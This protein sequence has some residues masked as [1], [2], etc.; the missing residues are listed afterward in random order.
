MR[1][2]LPLRHDIQRITDNIIT[3]LSEKNDDSIYL[4][5]HPINIHHATWPRLQAGDDVPASTPTLMDQIKELEPFI[6]YRWIWEGTHYD[7]LRKK[8]PLLLHIS[9]S[10][11]LI[12]HFITHWAK[13]NGG[14][15]LLS[16]L[17]LQEISSH[18]AQYSTFYTRKSQAM[19]FNWYPNDLSLIL[20]SLIAYKRQRLL[21]TIHSVI[22]GEGIDDSFHWYRYFNSKISPTD[23]QPFRLTTRELTRISELKKYHFYTALTEVINTFRKT[24]FQ[25]IEQCRRIHTMFQKLGISQYWMIT[26]IVCILLDTSSNSLLE[27]YCFILAETTISPENRLD[28]MS[29]LKSSITDFSKSNYFNQLLVRDWLTLPQNRGRFFYEAIETVRVFI[30]P[31]EDFFFPD[32]IRKCF[33]LT[34]H[35]TPEQSLQII[36]ANSPPLIYKKLA[37]QLAGECIDGR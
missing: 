36:E 4:L 6:H 29:K 22:W 27:W 24:T 16:P 35:A 11:S 30:A 37:S 34:C 3:Q 1:S 19:R 17:S 21:S 31:Q 12:Q 7:S 32:K 15:I 33:L 20:G 23:S 2:S 8:G 5:L 26:E 25:R 18:F 10:L 9:D 14:L 28:A 13:H